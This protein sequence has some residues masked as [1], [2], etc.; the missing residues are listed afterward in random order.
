MKTRSK[1]GYGLGDVG[2][3][4]LWGMVG[5]VMIY[6][7]D[8]VGVSA[9]ALGTMMLC[10]RVFD[11]VS[12][13]LM[14]TVI[15]NTH[16]KWGKAR[17]WLFGSIAPLVITF[18]MLFNVPGNLSKNGKATYFFILYFIVTAVFY[19]INNVSYNALPA[20][21]TDSTKDRVSMS[22]YRYVLSLTTGVAL[23]VVLVP[24]I[25]SMGGLSNQAAWTKVTIVCA[26]IAV[27]MLTVS[28]LSVKELVTVKKTDKET[29]KKKE[30]G[31]PFY[32]A[33]GYTF[34][35]KY[36]LLQLAMTIF[37][38][39]RLGLTGAGVYYAKCNL[40]NPD[41]VGLLGIMSYLPMILG[42]A[43]APF[44]FGKIGMKRTRD[45]GNAV[46]LAGA[47][48]AAIFADNL[49]LMLIG[50]GLTALGAGPNTASGSA[51]LAHVADYS[52]WKHHVKLT[53]TTF[54]CIGVATKIAT[55]LGAALIGWG[56][57]WGG[58]NAAADVQTPD[59]LFAIKAVF[60]YIP[61]LLSVL[62]LV[63][64]LFLDVEKKMPKI[65]EELAAR[66]ELKGEL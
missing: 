8:A 55:G 25:N 12:D 60:L 14:G 46:G 44:L 66:N 59:T 32:K 42:M 41:L 52:E 2:A 47:L 13:A 64:N 48:L 57:A 43:P 22:I 27:T 65:K 53:G 30:K 58:Y 18:I 23:S 4:T 20:L 9:A 15:D 62:N 10:A 29:G 54:S 35:N 37:T 17:P 31:V 11:G 21:V 51:I 56:L 38:L 39:T 3:G 6:M 40:G 36:F 7:T 5:F 1:L 34:S 63:C 49:V 45:I 24:V 33:F 28:G 26:L 16:T 61:V 19:T 50:L